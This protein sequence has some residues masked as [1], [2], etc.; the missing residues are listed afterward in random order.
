MIL[1]CDSLSNTQGGFLLALLRKKKGAS[2]FHL[3]GVLHRSALAQTT[4]CLCTKKGV[5]PFH[6]QVFCNMFWSLDKKIGFS[7]SVWRCFI[8]FALAM[9]TLCLC[10]KNG[11]THF[12][13]DVFCMNSFPVQHRSYMTARHLYIPLIYS[14]INYALRLI[15]VKFGALSLLWGGLS[16]SL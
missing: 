1:L 13:A 6:L 9:S 16:R 7:M 3:A 14:Q 2:P 8:P 5:N 10:T 15:W 4:R 11:I 12:T